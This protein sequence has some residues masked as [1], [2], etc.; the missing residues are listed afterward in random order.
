LVI[1]EAVGEEGIKHFFTVVTLLVFGRYSDSVLGMNPELE[2]VLH[3][4]H[5]EPDEDHG[6]SHDG[7]ADD[8]GQC[9]DVGVV[10]DMVGH[11]GGLNAGFASGAGVAAG[12]E[13][14]HDAFDVTGVNDFIEVAV[15]EHP[16]L[17]DKVTVARPDIVGNVESY[18]E[19][20]RGELPDREVG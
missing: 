6:K 19:G 7:A 18:E 17:T 10:L 12:D 16:E 9:P 1:F 2:R 15:N 14:V 8:D 5:G 20:I 3:L 4:E 13:I 11:V